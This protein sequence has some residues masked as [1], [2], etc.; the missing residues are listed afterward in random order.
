MRNPVRLPPRGDVA[1]AVW[2]GIATMLELQTSWVFEDHLEVPGPGAWH[3]GMVVAMACALAFRRV[4]PLVAVP[5]VLV[6]YTAGQYVV[7]LPNSFGL[8]V[9]VI[10]AVYSVALYARTQRAAVSVGLAMVLLGAWQGFADPRDPGGSASAMVIWVTLVLVVGFVVRRYRDR[11]DSM[12]VERDLAATQAREVAAQERARVARE[13]HDVVAHGMSVVVLQ[14]RGGRR[15]LAHDV[16]Q[17][18]VAFDD[19]DRVASDCLDEMRRLLGILRSDADMAAPWAPQPRLSE[20]ENL[21]VQARASGAEVELVVEGRRREL[22]PAIELS[23]YRIGQEALTN[24]LQHAAGSR[25]RMRVVYEDTA[26]AIEVEDSGSGG[27][28]LRARATV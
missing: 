5:A 25:T 20:L 19:I 16:D 22:A 27:T 4:Y 14:A 13:L 11:T 8:S 3:Y 21:V 23:A 1:L 24:A 9:M 28:R 7:V 18:R 17:A 10:V 6:F 26:I 12:R 15:M 2:L